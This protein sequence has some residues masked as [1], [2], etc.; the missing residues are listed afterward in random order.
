MDTARTNEAVPA[1]D[2]SQ[3]PSCFP[4]SPFSEDPPPVQGVK[5]PALRTGDKQCGVLPPAADA[6]R[7]AAAA[8]A[9]AVDRRVTPSSSATSTASAVNLRMGCSED[10]L[11]GARLTP[12]QCTPCQLTFSS[13]ADAA[14]VAA[15]AA[16]SASEPAPAPP[17]ACGRPP[18]SPFAMQAESPANTSVAE[19]NW[20]REAEAG[21]ENE[22]IEK[23]R[24]AR[25]AAHKLSQLPSLS[26]AELLLYREITDELS[27]EG[28]LSSLLSGLCVPPGPTAA[29]C[30]ARSAAT[31]PPALTK[32]VSDAVDR[33]RDMLSPSLISRLET[34]ESYGL[35][36]VLH[37]Q[38][39]RQSMLDAVEAGKTCVGCAGRR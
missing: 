3:G 26:G 8:Q 35:V 24:T 10:S 9:L 38:D 1:A 2:R 31:A 6:A 12:M 29:S 18:L 28:E 33:L 27:S 22:R 23:R 5:V 19:A 11:A 32:E 21:G 37:S 20:G 15:A 39:A 13:S 16:A 25:V 36:D 7:R 34:H 4:L 30:G 14:A 17:G